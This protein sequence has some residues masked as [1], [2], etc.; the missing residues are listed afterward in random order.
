MGR[1]TTDGGKVLVYA[2]T[3]AQGGA[4]IQRLL[5]LGREVRGLVRDGR[6]ADTLRTLGAEPVFGDLSDPASLKAASESAA[7]VFLVLPLEFDPKKVVGW[8]LN[9]IDAAREAGVG[10]LVFNTSTRVPP[11]A[12]DVAVTGPRSLYHSE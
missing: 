3:G 2:A 12:T 5:P 9:A 4:V 7:A 10:R 11:E 8:G 6:G 1:E